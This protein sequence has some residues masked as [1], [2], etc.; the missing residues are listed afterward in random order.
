[1]SSLLLDMAQFSDIKIDS[2]PGLKNIGSLSKPEKSEEFIKQGK[3]S[4]EEMLTS[5]MKEVNEL[6]IASDDKIRKLATG[7]VEDIS[8]VV[9]ASSRAEVALRM[10]M[11]LRN[12]F[13]DAYQQLSRISA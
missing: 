6:Q 5:S 12:K 2:K 4:F 13:V 3:I 9:L 1:M 7:D 8:E 11:E 10:F